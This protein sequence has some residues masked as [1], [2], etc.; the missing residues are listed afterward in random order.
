[1]FQNPS[2]PSYIHLFL[3]NRTSYL[4]EAETTE[5]GLS[6]FYKL[7][8]KVAKEE[9]TKLPPTIIPHRNYK[10]FDK[11]GFELVVSQKLPFMT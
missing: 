9:I 3:T 11:P 6:D 1:M 10:K 8:V 2:N 4:I 5:S 7:R